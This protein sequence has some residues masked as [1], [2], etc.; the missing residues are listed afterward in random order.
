MIGQAK[1]ED[2]RRT[3]RP[4]GKGGVCT[5][6]AETFPCAAIQLLD[7]LEQ[8]EAAARGMFDQVR[9][10]RARQITELRVRISELEAKI[11]RARSDLS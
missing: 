3:H 9:Q 8:V 11:G 5:T 10:E 2:I 4:V 1:R 6:C 7:E